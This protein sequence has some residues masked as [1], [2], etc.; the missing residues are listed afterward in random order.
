MFGRGVKTAVVFSITVM[1]GACPVAAAAKK[2]TDAVAQY[3]DDLA[4]ETDLQSLKK[5]RDAEAQRIRDEIFTIR[6]AL[7]NDRDD[8]ARKIVERKVRIV[9]ERNFLNEEFEKGV[10]QVYRNGVAHFDQKDYAASR[11]DFEEIEKLSPGFKDTRDY[12]RKLEK[13]PASRKKA[14]SSDMAMNMRQDAVSQYTK[15]KGGKK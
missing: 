9:R 12:L 13:F 4:G 2:Q 10:D 6:P 7:K 3:Y 11:M 5:K 15:L 8:M 14:S 1:A